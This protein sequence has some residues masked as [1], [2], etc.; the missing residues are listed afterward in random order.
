MA[1]LVRVRGWDDPDIPLL[2]DAGA[3]GIIVPDVATADEARAVVQTSRFPPDGARSFAA[4]AIG[5]GY[6]GLSPAAAARA[7]NDD[8]L[9]VCMIETP[10]GLANAAE[11]AAVEGVDMSVAGIC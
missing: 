2:L 3:T 8:M 7:L 5:L 10:E 4:P 9:V 6:A 11:I 1:P